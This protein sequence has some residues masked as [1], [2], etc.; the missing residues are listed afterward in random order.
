MASSQPKDLNNTPVGMLLVEIGFTKVFGKLYLIFWYTKMGVFR[1]ISNCSWLSWCFRQENDLNF[2][3][4]HGEEAFHWQVFFLGS[5]KCT[6]RGFIK[7]IPSQN[8]VTD[9]LNCEQKMESNVPLNSHKYVLHMFIFVKQLLDF[10]PSLSL[11]LFELFLYIGQRSQFYVQRAESRVKF[12]WSLSNP[13]EQWWSKVYRG[14][15]YPV[16]WGL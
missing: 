4:D 12:I 15:Y 8:G 3:W 11:F 5:I 13:M 7:R 16:M 10:S 14:S 1:W 6:N 9:Y 2:S